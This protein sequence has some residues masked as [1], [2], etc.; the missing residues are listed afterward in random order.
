M[1]L[2]FFVF[3]CLSPVITYLDASIALEDDVILEALVVFLLDELGD[4][5]VERVRVIVDIIAPRCSDIVASRQ[6]RGEL[7]RKKA[8]LTRT[9]RGR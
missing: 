3:S 8:P 2:L 5:R 7:D 6:Q 1:Y 9:Q 4:C